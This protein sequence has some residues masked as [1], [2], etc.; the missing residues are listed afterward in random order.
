MFGHNRDALFGIRVGAVFLFYLMVELV[1]IIANIVMVQWLFV[2]H[3][4]YL[5]LYVFG[6]ENSSAVCCLSRK[7][8]LLP[9]KND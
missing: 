7:I 9:F 6:Q 3:N 4:R 1:F 5:L 2:C 8:L